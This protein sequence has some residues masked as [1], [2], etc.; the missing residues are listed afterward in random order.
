[1]AEAERGMERE[2]EGRRQRDKRKEINAREARAERHEQRGTSRE[3]GDAKR[4]AKE[5]GM[6]V[7]E[8]G[9]SRGNAIASLRPQL[10]DHALAYLFLRPLAFFI[11]KPL[12]GFAP[13]TERRI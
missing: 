3:A 1:M 12:K 7:K 9:V 10:S 8:G 13:T 4:G 6:R 5:K 11:R 2:I